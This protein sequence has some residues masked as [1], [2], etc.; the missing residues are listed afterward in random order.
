MESKMISYTRLAVIL[1]CMV[2]AGNLY[3]LTAPDE[4]DPASAR[5]TA[6][7]KDNPPVKQPPRQ[8]AKPAD[9]F[10]PTERIDADSAVSFPVDI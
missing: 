7:Q 8:P 4:T 1:G 5:E 10:E 2:A 9:T 6:A 3:A